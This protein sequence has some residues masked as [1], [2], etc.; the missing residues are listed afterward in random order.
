MVQAIQQAYYLHARNPSEST[1]LVE[2][3]GEIGLDR[4]RF[5]ADLAS[6]V[7]EARLQKE[8]GLCHR[9]GLTAFPAL[10]LEIDGSRWPLP[11]DYTDP[12]PMLTLIDLLLEMD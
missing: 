4:E 10:A 1:T 5:A 11:V 7:T 9:L 2:L 6:D 3:A 12:K 8:I